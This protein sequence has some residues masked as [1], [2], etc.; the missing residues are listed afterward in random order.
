[1][2]LGILFAGGFPFGYSLFENAFLCGGLVGVLLVKLYFRH[3]NIWVL[4]LNLRIPRFYHLSQESFLPRELKVR[5][6]LNACVPGSNLYHDHIIE[7]LL[8]QKIASLSSGERRYLELRIIL[9]LERLYYFLDEPFT[10]TAPV[11]IEQM[12]GLMREKCQSGAGILLTDHYTRYV[13]QVTDQIYILQ[14]GHC[15][16]QKG[17]VGCGA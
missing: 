9:H 4:F 13:E 11:L 5:R 17:P 1:M 14:N 15:R 10:G 3:R 16:Q 7:A 2:L 8:S 6:L 12:M